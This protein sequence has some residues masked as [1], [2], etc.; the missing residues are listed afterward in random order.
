VRGPEGDRG[1]QPV[2][3]LDAGNRA[4]GRGPSDSRRLE[5]LPDDFPGDL[6]EDGLLGVEIP[7]ERPV[8]DA[9]R[10]G[11]VADA[12]VEEALL[13][14]HLAGGLHERRPGATP[15]QCAG[16]P[17]FAEATPEGC[18]PTGS[19]PIRERFRRDRLL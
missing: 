18:A 7:V 16:F 6:L 14:E 4:L 15:F 8:G 2:G 17:L 19:F 3:E 5:D 13:L 1:D 11:D 9:R 12:G 10:L